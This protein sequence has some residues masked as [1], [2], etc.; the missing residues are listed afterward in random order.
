MSDLP[1]LL[2]ERLKRRGIIKTVGKNTQKD[3]KRPPIVEHG[4]EG[5][6]DHEEILA[7]NY[8]DSSDSEVDE[9]QTD[10]A[11]PDDVEDELGHESR[12]D[13]TERDDESDL[14]GISVIGCPNKYN[15]YHECSKYCREQY[16]CPDNVTPN[17]DQRRQLALVL[18]AYPMPNEWQVVYDPGV[19]TFYFWNIVT[20][21]VSWLPPVMNGL[22]SVSADEIRKSIKATME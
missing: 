9:P 20:N 22:V 8:S 19:K 1:P 7:E 15:I 3:Q 18:K 12:S 10:P 5:D 6:P 2:L 4:I 11:N 17:F 13:S 14:Q 16:S 21:L